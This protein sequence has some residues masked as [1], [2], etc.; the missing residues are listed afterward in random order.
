VIFL[1]FCSPSSFLFQSFGLSLLAL[2]PSLLAGW[3]CPSL[4]AG[5]LC[6]CPSLLHRSQ[7]AAMN[8]DGSLEVRATQ[9]TICSISLASR[10]RR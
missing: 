3:L 6:P 1:R 5:W 10:R 8:G 4:L 2:S 7:P 9:E